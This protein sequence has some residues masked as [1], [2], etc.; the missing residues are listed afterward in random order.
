M[1]KADKK[2]TEKTPAKVNP[3]PVKVNP[4]KAKV[5]PFDDGR[6]KKTK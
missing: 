4:S 2:T 1:R 6:K 3:A 5:L